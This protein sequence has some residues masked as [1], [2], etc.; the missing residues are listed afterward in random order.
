MKPLYFWKKKKSEEIKSRISEMKSGIGDKFWWWKYNKR[1]RYENIQKWLLQ[2]H[3][4]KSEWKSA[5]PKNKA[6][7]DVILDWIYNIFE[8]IQT[9]YSLKTVGLENCHFCCHFA[10]FW[11]RKTMNWSITKECKIKI[12][13]SLGILVH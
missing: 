1:E 11:H 4:I 6:H 8:E 7:V 2:F 10:S 9:I 3:H 5:K 12:F 13:V